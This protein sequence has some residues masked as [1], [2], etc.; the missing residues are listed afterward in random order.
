MVL[1]LL[2]WVA[3]LQSCAPNQTMKTITFVPPSVTQ[4]TLGSKYLH[5]VSQIKYWDRIAAANRATNFGWWDSTGRVVEMNEFYNKVI[6][7]TF[8]GTWSM[9]SL[10][11]L[12]RIRLA[13]LDNPDTNVLFIGVAMREPATDGAAILRVDSFARA[14]HVDYQLLI[15]SRD[16]GFTYGGI[17]AVPTTFVI[18]RSRKII[19][20]F[21]GVVSEGKLVDTVASAENNP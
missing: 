4:D 17:D 5:N 1:A 18:A 10:D 12:Y 11:Q 20:T 9:P 14:R 13:R 21:D 6:V 16:F 3:T 8:F 7:L 19:A 15:G 2:V